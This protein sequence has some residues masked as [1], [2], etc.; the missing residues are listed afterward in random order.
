MIETLKTQYPMIFGEILS[1]KGF[2]PGQ[3]YLAS[4][5]LTY[6]DLIAG[7]KTIMAETTVDNTLAIASVRIHRYGQE[8]VSTIDLIHGDA[9]IELNLSIWCEKG[10][11]DLVVAAVNNA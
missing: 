10:L 3:I 8:G 6:E 4:T 5:A 11:S 7:I 1:D 2:R 9:G